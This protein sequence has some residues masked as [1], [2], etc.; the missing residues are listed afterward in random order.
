MTY[1]V[2]GEYEFNRKE[3]EEF[4][5]DILLSNIEKVDTLIR[6]FPHY[7][8]EDNVRLSACKLARELG[9]EVIS[10]AGR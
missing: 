9:F 10:V 7:S 1:I 5:T 3:L 6:Y 2:N 4:V 8:L